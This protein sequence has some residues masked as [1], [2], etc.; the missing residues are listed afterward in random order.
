LYTLAFS[1][2]V[3]EKYLL[4]EGSIAPGK[5]ENPKYKR[6]KSEA[7]PKRKNQPILTRR[8]PLLKPD[9]LEYYHL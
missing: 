6:A 7:S 9:I 3:S 2:K 5:R 1:A 4:I 8:E